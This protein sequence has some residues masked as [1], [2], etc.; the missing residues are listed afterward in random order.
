MM[1][2]LQVKTYDLWDRST[3]E[4]YGWLPVDCGTSGSGIC[5]VD[6]WKPLGGLFVCLL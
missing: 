2:L 3:T 1:G 6:T 4:G 5:Y